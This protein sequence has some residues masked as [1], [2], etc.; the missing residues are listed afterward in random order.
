VKCLRLRV[1]ERFSDR[2]YANPIGPTFQFRVKQDSS[3]LPIVFIDERL[4]A[5]DKPSGMLAVP[6]L[7]PENRDNLADRLR[8][9]YPDA[10][11]VHRLDRDTSGLI[12]FA[13]DIESQRHLSRQFQDRQAEKI[14]IAI[15]C[16]SVAADTG[17]VEPPLKRDFA[18]PPRYRVDSV[19]GKPATTD[20]RVLERSVDRTRIELIPLTGRS[21]QLRVH[22]QQLGH[23]ILGDK[24]YASPEALNMAERLML[25]AARLTILHPT[26]GQP[27]EL[28]A[29][30][31]F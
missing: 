11:V 15:V 3:M 30:C 16:G 24:L 31:P 19:H 6:G 20:W 29:K 13:R 9:E 1:M 18:R 14:Y 4:I 27:L 2:V 26:N 8:Q 5:L 22:M 25:H 7:G 23:P 21:H 28:A 10:L 17:R 12:V